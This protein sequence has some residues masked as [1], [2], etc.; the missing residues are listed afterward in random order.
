MHRLGERHG[1]EVACFGH[2]GDGNVHV[3]L[4]SQ[5][6]GKFESVLPDV[7]ADVVS[8]TLELGG[9]I[10]G[11]HGTG[12]V[13]KQFVGR[14]VGATEREIMGAIKHAIDPDGLMNPG[15]IL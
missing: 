13:K 3:G 6:A 14:A 12:Y 2:A 15:K 11:E 1:L 9:S 8:T 10:S 5:D 4:M 7:N